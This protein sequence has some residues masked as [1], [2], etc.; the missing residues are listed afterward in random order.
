MIKCSHFRRSKFD[1]KGSTTNCGCDFKVGRVLGSLD[2]YQAA[3]LNARS[4][5]V[6]ILPAES[7]LKKHW[8]RFVL[9]IC[10]KHCSVGHWVDNYCF[11]IHQLHNPLNPLAVSGWSAVSGQAVAWIPRLTKEK[12][13]SARGTASVQRFLLLHETLLLEAF[14]NVD[15]TL[16][17]CLM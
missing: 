11:K 2:V 1:G 13:T 12:W 9:F 17:W 14:L 6:A 10:M 16:L 3:F 4:V 8:G 7:K 5:P 15:L